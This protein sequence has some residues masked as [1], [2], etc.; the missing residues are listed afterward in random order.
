VVSVFEDAKG[1]VTGGWQ[2]L[3]PDIASVAN[4]PAL[5]PHAAAEAARFAAAVQP[6]ADAAA[7]AS[8]RAAARA[9][10]A[11]VCRPTFGTVT[12]RDFLTEPAE[13]IRHTGRGLGQDWGTVIH[14]LLELAVQN[15]AA[16]QAE[17]DLAAAAASSV[18]ASDL[19]ESGLD[20]QELARRATTL[21]E[22]VL[23]STAWRR[24]VASPERYV[25]VPFTIAVAAA[26]IP[27]T[28]EVDIG[29][30]EAAGSDGGACAAAPVVIRGQIDAVFR[31]VAVPPPAGMSDWVI[32][33]WKTTSVI[34]ADEARLR[35]HY[36][37]QLVLYARCWAADP[38]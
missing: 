20:R 36:A 23:A 1:N 13:R 29:P 24:I 15:L 18:E 30:G 14:R 19:A 8:G 27:P 21:V 16:P 9:A 35:E 4:L 12:P 32:L 10:I 17:F 26:E 28:V 2:E 37:P 38:S 7:L 22:E 5:E 33:D 25:E 3:A 11:T 31:D 34:D 6:V